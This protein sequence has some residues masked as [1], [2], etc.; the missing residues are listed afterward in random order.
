MLSGASPQG[1]TA[2]SNKSN[3]VDDPIADMLIQV[4]NGYMA[5][6]KTVV[7]PWSKVKEALALVLARSGYISEARQIDGEKWKELNLELKYEGKRAVLTGVRRVSK[8]SLR[9][10][11][12][13]NH[14]PRVLG[15]FGMAIISTS[16]GLMS[17]RQARKEKIGGE[18]ICEVW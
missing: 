5:R 4:K 12:D 8:P 18:V 16:R 7:V 15:G 10:Y 9:L 1:G 14:L 2:G 17:D 13:H 6:K 3:M 11:A